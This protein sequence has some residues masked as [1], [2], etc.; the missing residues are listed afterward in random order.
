SKPSSHISGLNPAIETTILKCLAVD[1]AERP[2]SAD[3]VLLGLPGDALAAALA[4]GETPSPRMVADAGEVGLIRPWVAAAI[5]AAI[6]ALLAV[7]ALLYPQASGFA[8]VGGLPKSTD[9]FSGKAWN[10]R[11]LAG[12]PDG[13]GA[14]GY[15]FDQRLFDWINKND[16]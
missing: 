14:A 16:Q 3:S 2:Q 11:D 4:A 8:K 13:K 6:L 10:V 12:Y 15:D 1:P 9:W 5:L 7:F